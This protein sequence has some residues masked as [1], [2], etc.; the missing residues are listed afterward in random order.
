MAA[1]ACGLL[2][3]AALLARGLLRL[4]GVE[5]VYPFLRFAGDPNGIW[6]RNK[7]VLAAAGALLWASIAWRCRPRRRR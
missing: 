7:A 5:C 3:L 6:L 2:W 4:P 1:L